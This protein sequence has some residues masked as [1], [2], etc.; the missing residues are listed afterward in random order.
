MTA[1]TVRTAE[2]PRVHSSGS[3]GSRTADASVTA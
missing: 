2:I 1:T 3:P